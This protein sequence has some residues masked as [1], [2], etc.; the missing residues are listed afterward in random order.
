MSFPGVG[1][2][3][4]GKP[5]EPFGKDSGISSEG[6]STGRR[7]NW[8]C[9]IN[10]ADQVKLL[11]PSVQLPAGIHGCAV[12]KDFARDGKGK[13]L[14]PLRPAGR[15]LGNWDRVLRSRFRSLCPRVD[16][17]C[18]R[19][20]IRHTTPKKIMVMFRSANAAGR[21]PS[22]GLHRGAS[23]RTRSP[24]QPTSPKGEPAP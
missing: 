21:L 8:P 14:V 7:T 10:I 9:H 17:N 6:G 23:P 20:D 4:G 2:A 22:D 15:F 11:G 24:S 12:Y 13:R 1:A 19:C 18:L 5:F 16:R 3:P